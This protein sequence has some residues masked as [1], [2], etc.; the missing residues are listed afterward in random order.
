MIDIKKCGI[1]KKRTIKIFIDAAT[2]V[3]KEEGIEA[4][5]I[6]KV[7]DIAGYN[8]ATIYNYFDNSNKLVSFAAME[9]ISETYIKDL[10]DSIDESNSSLDNF[11]AIWRCF[12]EHCFKKPEIYYAVF[13]ENIGDQPN[14]LI[15]N[16][17]FLFPEEVADYPSKL[18]PMVMESDFAKR[19]E[20]MMEP[21]IQAGY[22]TKEEAEQIN[23]MIRLLY[24]GMLSLLINNRINYSPEEAT[25]KIMSYIKGL[26][27]SKTNFK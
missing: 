1:K 3:L 27:D 9:V 4:V 17:Y 23:E 16:Y 19:C 18:L 21:C 25:E 24:Q 22:F 20:L 7:A 2:K 26:I 11:L 6:R 8:S 14:D 12:C 13:T 15:G 5:T 10:P